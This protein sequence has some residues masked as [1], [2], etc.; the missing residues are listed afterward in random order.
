M[1]TP[2]PADRAPELM[3][4]PERGRADDAVKRRLEAIWSALPGW[5]YRP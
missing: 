1:P 5:R 2:P 4:V 3:R